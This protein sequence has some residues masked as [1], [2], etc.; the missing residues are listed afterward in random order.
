MRFIKNSR[1]RRGGAQQAF[2][3]IEL[4]IVLLVMGVIA[5]IAYPSYQ[6]SVRKT[7][8][9]EGRAALMELM[10][11][12]ERY[13]SQ[14]GTY[15]VFSAAAANGFKWFSADN[16]AAS[17]YEISAAACKDDVIQNCVL[18]IASPGTEKVN[19]KYRDDG[20]GELTLA[21]TGVKRA[22]GNAASCW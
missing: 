19:A 10:Q 3:L 9:A 18:I 20:C 16:A 8:R 14:H 12:Q 22:S 21:S 7:R 5:A 4:L 1:G 15:I 13:Y 6:E 2:T 17:S 11:Q